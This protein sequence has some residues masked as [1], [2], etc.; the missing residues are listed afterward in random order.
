MA[1]LVIGIGSSGL[2]ILE[3]AQE[4]NYEFLG[5]NIPD[6]EDITYL[7]LDTQKDR[8]PKRTTFGQSSI[9]HEEIGLT[10]ITSK[11]DELVANPN[12]STNWFPSRNQLQN[13]DAASGVP[14]YGRLALW[15]NFYKVD[16]YLE[17]LRK[18]G[19]G[20]NAR[21]FIVGSLTGGTGSG[22][23]VDLP[24]M[25]RKKVGED[26]TIHANFMIPSIQE[27]TNQYFLNS[28]LALKSIEYYASEDTNYSISFPD[29]QQYE[30][31]KSPYDLVSVV[32]PDYDSNSPVRN[33][34]MGLQE[35]FDLVGLYTSLLF[36]PNVAG[37]QK[38]FFTKLEE[39][40]TDARQ[41]FQMGKFSTWGLALAQ[42]PKQKIQEYLALN[43][44]R[45][46]IRTWRDD[47]PENEIG[48]IR[49]KAERAVVGV[50]NNSVSN[51][52]NIPIEGINLSDYAEIWA[53]NIKNNNLEGKR[54]LDE[55]LNS[56]LAQSSD[57]YDSVAR[58]I[59]NAKDGIIK[60][61]NESVS[62]YNG[63]SL[64]FYLEYIKSIAFQLN[65]ENQ[66]T[67]LHYWKNSLG[68]LPE[69]QNW[70]TLFAEE[71]E[72]LKQQLSSAKLI[73]QKES[74]I[75]EKVEDILSLLKMSF[76]YDLLK[77]VGDSIVNNRTLISN[78]GRRLVTV[79]DLE[80]F[81]AKLNAIE[82]SENN[83]ESLIDAR[84]EAISGDP[85]NRGQIF[86]YFDQGDNFDQEVSSLEQIIDGQAQN[87]AEGLIPNG[88]GILA[89]LRTEDERIP[90]PK[91][92][93]DIYRDI[94]PKII[95]NI[96]ILTNNYFGD[97]KV[98]NTIKKS[99]TN[100]SFKQNLYSRE[101]GYLPPAFA[102]LSGKNPQNGTFKN[103]FYCRFCSDSA[104]KLTKVGND[105]REENG[106]DRAVAF[107]D[108]ND[109]FFQIP[110]LIN[111][112]VAF[113]EYCLLNQQKDDV[114]EATLIPTR[115]LYALYWAEKHLI[116]PRLHNE[117]GN[118]NALLDSMPYLKQLED[119][120]G[121]KTIIEKDTIYQ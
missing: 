64:A 71:R 68:I 115:D 108:V 12:T 46:E 78:T 62:E 57:N 87:P 74:L 103:A 102:R 112:I 56:K 73:G 11:Y 105:L 92:P 42:Y 15:V 79:S 114:K 121:E 98:Y 88:Q 89:L 43:Y 40:R 37:Q 54:D 48:G 53:N 65:P 95:E 32:S 34:D 4:F 20:S 21:V 50:I 26:A 25:I 72:K 86:N 18:K 8:G 55:Y 14:T 45:E 16:Q 41:R 83:G 75:K 59:D 119:R 111:S 104:E 120:E 13:Q 44:A 1:T 19:Q 80:E 61:I 84:K 93:E 94:V 113:K 99:T 52:L 116:S 17:D 3:K 85:Q 96:R 36:L 82:R 22:I 70:P 109:N 110:A 39:R 5:K 29:G 31:Y 24:Y 58:A 38:D 33:P 7:S 117:E 10:D 66:D 81:K 60:D 6:N 101:N 47:A 63:K 76:L 69:A 67:I 30:S 51:Y 97:T 90:V 35:L 28:Y 106:F 77:D 9:K 100:D 27:E 49:G 118:L 107:G 2:D 23:C 91:K